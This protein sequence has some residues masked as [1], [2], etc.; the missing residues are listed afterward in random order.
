MWYYFSSYNGVRVLSKRSPRK[1]A[2]VGF[3]L[4]LGIIGGACLGIGELVDRA[5][6]NALPD[7]EHR[8]RVANDRVEETGHNLLKIEQKL[9][10]SCVGALKIY[11]PHN[12]LANAAADSVVG[13][14]KSKPEPVCGEEATDIRE[15]YTLLK[16]SSL[17]LEKA[18]K[19]T[20]GALETYEYKQDEANSREALATGG[21]IGGA[22]GSVVGGMIA[23]D[24]LTAT[25]RRDRDDYGGW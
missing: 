11:M 21:A 19:A 17:A 8:L 10:E 9:G 15:A 18:N 7:A 12:T 5:D 16:D 6:R 24:I 4:S 20:A 23:Y 14:I 25:R 2:A 1:A 3:S 13:D 22:E